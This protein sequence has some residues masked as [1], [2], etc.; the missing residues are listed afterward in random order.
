MIER[1]IIR[2]WGAQKIL[3]FY[4]FLTFVNFCL[5]LEL[6]LLNIDVI[7]NFDEFIVKLGDFLLAQIS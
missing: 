3:D 7:D 6:M 4:R 2:S 1:L 5:D